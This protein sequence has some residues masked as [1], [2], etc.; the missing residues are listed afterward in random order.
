MTRTYATSKGSGSS[1]AGAVISATDTG[2]HKNY[3][4]SQSPTTSAYFI[5]MNN[6]SYTTNDAAFGFSVTGTTLTFTNTLPSDLA[7]T[8]IVLICV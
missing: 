4:L 1:S 5:I 2:D 6:G 3:T 8:L 7:S